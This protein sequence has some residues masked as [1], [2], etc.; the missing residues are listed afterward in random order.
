MAERDRLIK[1]ARKFLEPDEQVQ[2]IF[3]AF[4]LRKGLLTWIPILEDFLTTY[5]HRLVVSTDKRHLVLDCGIK[6]GRPK[7]VLREVPRPMLLG[8]PKRGGLP[9]AVLGER[10]KVRKKYYKELR[11]ADAVAPSTPQPPG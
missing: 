4:T 8:M 6:V 2:A 10:L 1:Q 9:A 5:K 7:S 11:A 3:P